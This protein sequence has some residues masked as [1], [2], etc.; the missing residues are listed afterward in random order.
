MRTIKTVTASMIR[1]I[2]ADDFNVGL[3]MADSE[4]RR[5]FVQI[6]VEDLDALVERIGEVRDAVVVEKEERQKEATEA[7]QA[8]KSNEEVR[9]LLGDFNSLEEL[10]EAAGGVAK[11]QRESTTRTYTPSSTS[12]NKTFAIELYDT[13]SGKTIHGKAVNKKLTADIEN[14]EAYKTLIEKDPSMADFDTFMRKYSE[15]YRKE[16]K[17]NAEYNGKK[18]HIN[19]R[20]KLNQYA[21]V[22]FEAFKKKDKSGKSDS[23]LL[24]EFKQKFKIP[25]TEE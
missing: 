14:S 22:H 12:N 13:V 25:E 3:L 2:L 5:E 6:D 21:M 19:A 1:T 23:E 8:L 18:F 24:A 17:L 7:L 10:L 16:Y 20:G 15:E 11:V 4:R 9:K